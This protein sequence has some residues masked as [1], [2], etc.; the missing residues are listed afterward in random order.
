MHTWPTGILHQGKKDVLEIIID[1]QGQYWTANEN[2]DFVV[3]MF[4]CLTNS[5]SSLSSHNNVPL[6]WSWN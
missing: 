5:E 4:S 2:I 3:Q 1:L 6:H